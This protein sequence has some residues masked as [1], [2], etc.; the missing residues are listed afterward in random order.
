[1]KRKKAMQKNLGKISGF[2]NTLSHHGISGGNS[3]ITIQLKSQLEISV[4]DGSPASDRKRKS[5]TV[6]NESPENEAPH[7]KKLRGVDAY[8]EEG[9]DQETSLSLETQPG[10]LGSMFSP[11]HG[12]EDTGG[13]TIL[14]DIDDSTT[15]GSSSTAEMDSQLCSGLVD[16]SDEDSE[17]DD[18]HGSRFPVY[19]ERRTEDQG[20]PQ[21]RQ[22][23]TQNKENQ[24]DNHSILANSI[25][26][27]GPLQLPV[28]TSDVSP[29]FSTTVKSIVEQETSLAPLSET[30]DD[31]Q[32]IE[33][34]SAL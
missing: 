31:S 6:G 27:T 8:A 17:E 25:S 5:I 13:R 20:K 23:Q 21:Q 15:S 19:G 4:G 29:T 28:V 26:L 16:Y 34:S 10:E 9:E 2:K 32:S 30:K 33:A 3:T 1:V 18:E 14:E 11:P 24:E 22:S 12:H 7:K